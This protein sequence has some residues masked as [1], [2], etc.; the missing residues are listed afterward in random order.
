MVERFKDKEN[1]SMEKNPLN[2][3]F[4]RKL[5]RIKNILHHL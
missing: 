5:K 2:E 3:I 1:K 4:R